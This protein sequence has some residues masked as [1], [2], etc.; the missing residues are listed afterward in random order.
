MIP[1]V[2]LDLPP[3]RAVEWTLRPSAK[4]DTSAS[5]IETTKRPSF[6]QE[7]YYHLIEWHSRLHDGG[8]A[9][10]IGT[11]FESAGKVDLDALRAT[12]RYLL[13]RHE[14]LR[15]EFRMN[16][17]PDESHGL[18]G[19][20]QC[21]VMR[22]EAV[23]LDQTELGE[24]DD[25]KVLHDAIIERVDNTIDT[26]KGPVLLMG[27]G[28]GKEKTVAYIICDHIVTDGFSC[29]IKA[30]ELGTIYEAIIAGKEPQL[31][32]TGSYLEFGKQEYATSE[33]VEADDPRIQLWRGFVERNGHVFTE[34]PVDLHT[35]KGSWHPATCSVVRKLDPDEA[36]AFEQICRAEGASVMSGLLA[37]NGIA[38]H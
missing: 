28:V 10:W 14:T 13:A 23:A 25:V 17:D 35:K 19:L 38:L 9:G 24:F 16:P 21:D 2:E 31:P 15:T 4:V 6:S 27:A 30:H 12:F 18:F 11:T 7:L 33:R 1:F 3:G 20:L 36:G 37:V 32:E 29:A 26:N 34:F 22:P 5:V 8:L